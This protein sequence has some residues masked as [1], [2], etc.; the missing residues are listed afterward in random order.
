MFN[1]QLLPLFTIN[2]FKGFF[3]ITYLYLDVK[4]NLLY[5]Y[6]NSFAKIF[7]TQLQ[8]VMRDLLL[9]WRIILIFLSSEIMMTFMALIYDNIKNSEEIDVINMC[10]P[11]FQILSFGNN[12]R[13]WWNNPSEYHSWNLKY[14]KVGPYSRSI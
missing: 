14:N 1:Q 2:L 12:N 10:K 7:P 11:F 6:N 13:R 8:K 9:R 3:V 4:S 5:Q